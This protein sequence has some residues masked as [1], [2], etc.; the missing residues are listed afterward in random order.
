MAAPTMLDRLEKLINVDI[1]DVDTEL[2]TSVP[3]TP[4][5][6]TFTLLNPATGNAYLSRVETS[7]QYIM[8]QELVKPKNQ[9][10]LRDLVQKYGKQGWEKVYD[11]AAVHFC[12]R[13]VYCL[14]GR[15]LLQV[16]LRYVNDR[17]AIIKQCRS[18]AEAFK[19]AGVCRNSFAIKLPFSGAAA[20]AALELNEEGIR[21]LAT[22]VFSLEQAIAASQSKCL[23]ISP[24]FNEIAAH[25]DLSLR[26]SCEDTA[27]QHPMSSRV[28]HILETYAKAYAETGQEQP[29]MIIASHFTPEEVFAMAEL[30]CRHVTIAAKPLKMLMDT[31]D[32]LPPVTSKKAKHPYANL[33]TPERLGA[34]SKID[35]LAGPNWSMEDLASM[36]T[37]YLS[38]GGAKLDQ[39]IRE[40]PVVSKRFRDA[41]EFFLEAEE[42][43]RDVILRE[44]AA[45]GL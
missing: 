28:V 41:T 20:S 8:T 37:D 40:D 11:M 27:L 7:N 25:F 26:P 18:F 24:Y 45:A 42:K 10:L 5:N 1:D 29:I 32:T 9:A 22:T 39:F 2:I 43:A 17:A 15:V 33:R 13:N 35:P 19:E 16:S 30:G 34:L 14:S 4:H 38:D 36:E 3:F 23:F 31:P 44:I 21:T 12:A 6:R